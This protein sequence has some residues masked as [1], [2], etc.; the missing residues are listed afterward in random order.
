MVSIILFVLFLAAVVFSIVGI[1][2]VIG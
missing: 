1:S 2:Q